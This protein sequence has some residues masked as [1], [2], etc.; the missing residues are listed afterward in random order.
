MLGEVRVN[1]FMRT[2]LLFRN[3]V[4]KLE[5]RKDTKAQYLYLLSTA[6][7]RL[8]EKILVLL[9]LHDLSLKINNFAKLN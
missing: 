7:L 4:I 8:S 9:S 1:S 6:S 3:Y 5:S 2:F